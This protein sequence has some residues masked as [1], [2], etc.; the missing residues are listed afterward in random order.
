MS[1]MGEVANNKKNL[2][3]KTFIFA[4]TNTLIISSNVVLTV[5]GI[6]NLLCT[7]N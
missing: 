4:H 7:H 5:Q 2:F 1:L 3:D 6:Y